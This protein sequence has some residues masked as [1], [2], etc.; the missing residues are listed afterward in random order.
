MFVRHETPVM[1]IE[2]RRACEAVQNFTDIE[3][4]AACA[5]LIKEIEKYKWRLQ[6]ILKNQGKSPVERAKLKANAEIPIDGVKVTVDQSVCDETIIISDIFNL[7][8]MDA[9]ELVLSGESQK[10]HFDCLNRGLI[11]VVCYYDVHRLLAVLLRTML[12]WDKESMH[13]SLRGFI[14]QNFVQRTMFQHLLQLQASFNV[15]SEFHMLSQPHVNGL[16]GPR[17]QNLLR[18]VIEEIRENGA[19]A[20]YSLC[21]WGAEHANEFLTDIFPILKGVP[22]AEKF[23]SHH[24]SAWI[25]L[26]KLTS[27]NVL[28]Q[29]TTAAAVLSNL[30]KEIRNETVWSDQSVCGTVQL[31]CAIALRALAVSPA[32]HLN[33]TNVEVD[34]DKVV[35]RAIK[36][37]AMVFI[38]HGVIRCDSFK[39]CCT[40]VRVVDMMLKQL[41]ALFPAKLMEIER[42]SEDE[43]TWVDEMAEKGQQAT[44][45]L[46][47]ENLL[48]CISD[49]YQIAD[50]PKASVV[51][52]ECITELSMAYS[53]SGSM[54]LC[55]FMERARLSHHVV[56]AV[57][58]LDMLCAICRT[59]QVAAFIFDIFARVPAH[60]DVNVGWDHVMSALRSYERLFRERTGTTSMFGHTLSAQQQ[61]KAVIPPRE[62]IGLITWVNLA[63]TMVDLDDDAAEVFL[64]ERQWA[65]LDAALG[66]VSAPVPL[67]LKGA[68][69]R[70][71]AALAKREASALRIWNALNAHGLCTF[72]ENGSLQGL[73]RELD[74]RECAEEMF[75]SS[76]GFVHLLRSLLSHSHITIPEFA[77]PYLQYLTKSIVSQMASRSYKDIGQ[78]FHERE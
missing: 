15:T 76:L 20:L 73:Q 60:D 58:Y 55:R 53:S 2:V 30:V 72:A 59:R 39:M 48:R 12:E 21:E 34:V 56:H 75:D 3:D 40:H 26:V 78:F 43:L 46:H 19:E 17:H 22:L 38:R 66:V 62:L 61:P 36:N 4:A 42:N 70:L 71:V 68:L 33:I 63:R 27:S 44:P 23:S 10:I 37:L 18:N 29:T 77:A 11:A 41:I 35:D 69:L 67:P 7:N 65:V 52:K 16:G 14:E 54:E 25:C 5:E 6:N 45:A 8:E 51:L 31:A 32:D 13:E 49:L 1:W 9:L 47:Y 50:D 74:E 24:L 57:A 64:E 28:S